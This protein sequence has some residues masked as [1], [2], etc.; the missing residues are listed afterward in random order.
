MLTLSPRVGFMH[1]KRC[2]IRFAVSLILIILVY[3]GAQL[4]IGQDSA[5]TLKDKATGLDWPVKDSG[6]DM[7]WGQANNYCKNLSLDGHR[8]WRL[9]TMKELQTVYDKSQSKLFKAKAP[10]ELSE[11][12]M[13][14]EASS[15]GEAWILSFL[16]GGTSMLPTNGS[17]S[18]KARALC[19]RQSDK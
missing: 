2:F 14:G 10:I 6:S 7:S 5:G 11:E 18:T 15:S 8:D 17:C 12:N 3:A 4:A 9:P 1:S 13:S 19:V 16:N